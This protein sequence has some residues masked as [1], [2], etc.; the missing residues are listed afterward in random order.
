MSIAS[1]RAPK[2][3]N[4][5]VAC[6][7]L[8]LVALPTVLLRLLGRL[9]CQPVIA[10][11][12]AVAAGAGYLLYA[13]FGYVGPAVTAAAL[14]LAPLAWRLAHG[15]SFERF[16]G[17]HLRNARV[18]LLRYE[19]RW[20]QVM[21]ANGLTTSHVSR[22]GDRKTLTPRIAR[23][24]AG[25]FVH[26]V[27]VRMRDGQEPSLFAAQALELA[28]GFDALWVRVRADRRRSGRIRGGRVWLDFQRE[29][30]LVQPIDALPIPTEPDPGAVQVGL[31]DDGSPWTVR[32][33]GSHVLL[34]G[35]TRAGKSSWIW[36]MLRNVGPLI[37]SGEVRVWA[38]D[39]KGGMELLG[40][41]EELFERT[42]ANDPVGLLTMLKDLVKVM[43]ER[44]ERQRAAKQRVHVPTVEE[45]HYI[46]ILDELIAAMIV[47]QRG[48][49]GQLEGEL[50]KLMVMAAACGITVVAGAQN[51]LKAVIENRDEF[52]VR[53][54]FRMNAA[55]HPDATFF[56]GARAQGAR[57]DDP[58]VIPDSMRGLALFRVDGSAEFQRGRVAFVPTEEIIEMAQQYGPGA[59]PVGRVKARLEG[60][61][62]KGVPLTAEQQV[63]VDAILA[64]MREADEE[65]VD[66]EPDSVVVVELERPRS[67]A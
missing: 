67:A 15:R 45:P 5:L 2:R 32:L 64:T 36:S 22:D 55:S 66:A 50:R 48:L 37:K 40:P 28:H 10:V 20:R 25:L 61:S 11:P 8:V 54:G 35:A 59:T 26:R 56:D 53:I 23:V 3:D 24:D 30:P 19:L 18:R 60:R 42:V 6:L 1:V 13:R 33:L 58:A 12:L 17:R 43:E 47:S 51:P 63:E 46:L 31:L 7:D 21:I 14:V 62:S 49:R 4:A 57:C 41:G 16:M 34:I 27:L 9:L 39:P 52:T 65:V 44:G 38:S 29:D